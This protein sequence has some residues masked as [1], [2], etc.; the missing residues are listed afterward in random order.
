V[1]RKEKKRDTSLG[2]KKKPGGI[3]MGTAGKFV[4]ADESRLPGRT[5]GGPKKSH[6]WQK[7]KKKKTARVKKGKRGTDQCAEGRP[8]TFS[9]K[10]TGKGNTKK[11]GNS[12]KKT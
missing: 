9:S 5:G 3:S 1:E 12:E 11:W 2:K 8:A 10:L 4:Q 7:G 6:Q